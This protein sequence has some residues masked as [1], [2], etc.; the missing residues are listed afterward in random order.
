MKKLLLLA[1]I[2]VACDTTAQD[3]QCVPERAAMI[4]II[5]AYGANGQIREQRRHYR[6]TITAG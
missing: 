6:R 2:A 1:F 5:R 4:E 3:A